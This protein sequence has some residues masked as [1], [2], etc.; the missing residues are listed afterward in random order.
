M[1]V[2]NRSQS[3]GH[4][5]SEDFFQTAWTGSCRR[6]GKIS[7]SAWE[8]TTA[9]F[10]SLTLTHSHVLWSA[11]CGLQRRVKARL[12]AHAAAVAA[13]TVNL[14][15]AGVIRS[16]ASRW[17]KGVLLINIIIIPVPED[18]QPQVSYIDRCHAPQWHKRDGTW[19]RWGSR[20]VG[21]RTAGHRR[22]S[23]PAEK[24]GTDTGAPP[25]RHSKHPAEPPDSPAQPERC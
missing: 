10:L 24:T 5:H 19:W 9:L 17:V 1:A 11:R 4:F 6:R 13:E 12:A 15:S 21:R 14:S 20:P 18:N 22:H 25:H 16:D 7:G 2:V 8:K 23:L 3:K